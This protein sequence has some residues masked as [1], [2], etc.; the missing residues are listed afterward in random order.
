MRESVG[1]RARTC[2]KNMHEATQ[3]HS[4]TATLPIQSHANDLVS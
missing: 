2:H 4:L 3:K 1:P